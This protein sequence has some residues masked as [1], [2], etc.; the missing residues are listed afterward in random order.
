MW[1]RSRTILQM[2]LFVVPHVAQQSLSCSQ[3]YAFLFFLNL[4]RQVCPCL[5]PNWCQLD[6]VPPLCHPPWS[7]NSKKVGK[8]LGV[9]AYAH[10]CPPF[11]LYLHPHT[12]TVACCNHFCSATASTTSP[13]MSNLYAR[14]S[15][16][17]ECCAFTS[18]EAGHVIFG[19]HW[20]LLG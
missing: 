5:P 13:A 15:G 4:E 8:F 11:L 19:H 16:I 3:Q 14:H 6:S 2:G 10:L 12:H 9:L 20:P 7:G 1:Y 18:H 17:P